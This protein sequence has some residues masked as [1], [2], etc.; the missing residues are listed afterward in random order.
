MFDFKRQKFKYNFI[1]I[2]MK[3]TSCHGDEFEKYYFSVTKKC[4]CAGRETA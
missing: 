1:D 2:H 4:N 3:L